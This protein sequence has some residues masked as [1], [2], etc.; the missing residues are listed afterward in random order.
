MRLSVVCE[1]YDRKDVGVDRFVY[2]QDYRPDMPLDQAS[3]IDKKHSFSMAMKK[4]IVAMAQDPLELILDTMQLAKV[5]DKELTNE[6][7]SK[8]FDEM[9]TGKIGFNM[10][11]MDPEQLMALQQMNFGDEAHSP[12]DGSPVAAHSPLM[13]LRAGASMMSG[14]AGGKLSLPG[15]VMGSAAKTPLPGQHAKLSMSL[16]K[17]ISNMFKAKGKAMAK[18]GSPL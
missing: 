7:I 18:G 9:I 5:N 14:E 11:N 2:G 17:G 13:K 12:T 10:E 6:V 4:K 3:M 15:S 16:G 8:R 1:F